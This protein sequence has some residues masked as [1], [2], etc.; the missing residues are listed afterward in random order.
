MN[1]NLIRNNDKLAILIHKLHLKAATGKYKIL[2]EHII[3]ANSC[4]CFYFRTLLNACLMDVKIPQ[5]RTTIVI[6]HK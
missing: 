4:V 5:Q 3:S 1:N 6:V 2:D